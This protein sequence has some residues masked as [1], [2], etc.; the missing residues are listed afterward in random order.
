MDKPFD[1]MEKH[2]R[3]PRGYLVLFFGLVAWGIAYIAL[4]TPE[5]SG[6][7][8]YNVFR[9]ERERS[10]RA[11]A[12]APASHENPYEQDPKAIAEGAGLYD[13][14]CAGC[15][16]KELRGD[17]GPSLLGHL[18]YGETDADKYT[19]IAGGRPNGMPGFADQLG[20]DRIWKT[21]AHIDSIRER[22]RS[23]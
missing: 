5:L 18:A 10:M 15:H 7:S 17:V 22:P 21:L 1:D 14:N 12:A 3:I 9:A 11:A 8:Q 20:R 6:W 19:S 16:G 4:Y 2:N 13:A 23:R